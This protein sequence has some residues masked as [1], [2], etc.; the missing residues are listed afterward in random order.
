MKQIEILAPAGSK[1]SLIGAINAKANAIYLAGKRFGARAFADNFADFEFKDIIDYAHLRGVLVYVTVN[2][3]IFDEEVSE[4]LTYTDQLVEFGVDALIV[5]D[6][7]LIELLS[8]RYPN[9][10]IHVSTQANVHN[11]YQAEFYKNLGAKRIVLA[12]ETPIEIIKQIKHNVDIE[13]EVFVHGALCVSYS[14]NCLMSSMLGGRSGNRGECAQPC[15]LPYTLLKDGTVVSD[16]T[17]LLS[18]KDLMTLP[19]LNQLIEAGVDSIKIE[20][21]MRK[22]EYVVQSVLSYH[23]AVQAFYL[24]N[25]VSFEEDEIKLRKLFN[26]GFTKG[27]LFNENHNEI[28]HDFR[29]NHMG[30]EI[31]KVI[32]C[33]NNK[34]SIRLIDS[35]EVNDGYRIIGSTKDYGNK[36]SRIIKD[37]ITVR[38]AFSGEVIK[39]DVT[40]SI[41]I[42]STVL[43]TTDNILETELSK[44]FNEDFKTIPLSGWV[45]AY[46]NQYLTLKISDG[47]HS[48]AVASSDSLAKAKTKPV[49]D[50]QILSQITKLGNTPFYFEKLDVKTTN[51]LFIPLKELNELRREAIKLLV[52]LRTFISLKQIIEESKSISHNITHKTCLNVRVTNLE[53]MMG[54]LE[55]N[56][57]TIFCDEI[58]TNVPDDKRLITSKKRVQ[59]DPDRKSSSQLISEVGSIINHDPD[60]QLYTDEY[61]NVTN[62]LSVNTLVKNHVSR[63]T[64]SLELSKERIFNLFDNYQRKYN[65]IPNLEI[66]AYGRVDLMISKCCPIAKTFKVDKNCNLCQINQYYLKHSNGLEFPLLNDGDCNVRIL[67]EKPLNLIEYAK[68]L[69]DY[70]I[71]L[72]LN[73]TTESKQ[74]VKEV[75]NA[76]SEAIKGKVTKPKMDK[77]TYGRFISGRK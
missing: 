58:I 33:A 43:K 46:E 50:S 52:N 49:V 2:T 7:G 54:A 24:N 29:P 63:V 60:F 41:D 42:G 12:R 35:L 3:L 13:V 68:E 72:R 70:G 18:T 71:S 30:V 4:L 22:P 40:E 53:Q 34:V 14:G 74:E 75:I 5:Q 11:S 66:V 32:D 57:E 67:N 15:R 1:Q 31:G 65:T 59:F 44:F 64:L 61:M 76:F 27:Y 10:D 17:Y 8:K 28:I 23:K 48:V 45:S 19:Y 39:L 55:T 47:K 20:G 6:L 26:R 77:Y 51:D 37:D 21:R 62:V 69:F 73:F 38:K 36:V 9:T 56:V 16:E 25:K